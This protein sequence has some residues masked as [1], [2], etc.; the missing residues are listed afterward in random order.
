MS[1]ARRQA[2]DAARLRLAMTCLSQT[3]ILKSTGTKNIR[4]R[5]YGQDLRLSS[6]RQ[7]PATCQHLFLQSRGVPQVNPRIVTAKWTFLDCP[8]FLYG[9]LEIRR[10]AVESHPKGKTS[11]PQ[12]SIY[13]QHCSRPAPIYIPFIQRREPHGI[14]RRLKEQAPMLRFCQ[15]FNAWT[16]LATSF[17]VRYWK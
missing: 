15:C 13:V 5:I 3:Q 6:T 4:G 11:S 14:Y 7:T 16:Q 9:L 17:S 10:T 2:L 12:I 8:I 1:L